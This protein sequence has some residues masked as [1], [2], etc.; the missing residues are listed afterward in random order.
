MADENPFHISQWPGAI[1]DPSGY[2]GGDRLRIALDLGDASEAHKQHVIAQWCARLP[3][4]RSVR[5]LNLW[6]H[7]TQDLFDAACTLDLECLQV[8]WSNVVDLGAIRHLGRLL[9]FYLGSSTRVQ[10]LEPLAVLPRLHTL[11]LENLKLVTDFT[12]LTALRS[13]RSLSVTGSMWTRQRLGSLQPFAQMTWL[14]SL[15]LD[16]AHV[17]SVRP[18]AQLSGL[19]QLDLGGRLP[20]SEYAWLAA[21]LPRTECRWFA[22]YLDLAPSG[23]GRCPRCQQDSR[24]MLTGKGGGVRCLHCDARRVSKHVAQF[25]LLKAQAT[26][27]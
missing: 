1:A 14:E 26:A 12:P 27:A 2:D 3:Q 10:S 9:Y 6:S 5:R 24:V 15:A 22:P 13:L 25:E 21:H 4:L 17:D 20:L 7:V 16:T 11:H 8:K 19:R 23:I 18:L